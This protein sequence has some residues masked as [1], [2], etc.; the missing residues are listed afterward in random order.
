MDF[1]LE[2]AQGYGIW[3]VLFV[4]LFIFELKSNSQREV[5]YQETIFENQDIIKR[6]TEKFVIVEEVKKDVEDIKDYVFKKK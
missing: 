4:F 5:K 3:A 2:I 1:L 6:L